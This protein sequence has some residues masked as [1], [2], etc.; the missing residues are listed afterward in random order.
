MNDQNKF[1]VLFEDPQFE[2]P[3]VQLFKAVAEGN[4]T[5]A[6]AALAHRADVNYVSP[7]LQTALHVAAWNGNIHMIHST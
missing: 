6:E 3:S 1:P 5:L 2:T 4:V 7:N